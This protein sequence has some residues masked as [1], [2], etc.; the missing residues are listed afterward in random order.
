MRIT[1]RGRYALRASLALVRIQNLLPSARLTDPGEYAP[2]SINQISEEEQISSVFLEQIF[3]KLRKAGIVSSVRGPGGGFLFAKSPG[4]I[5]L[6]EILD[7]AGEEL[8]VTDCDK[9]AK[10]C[11]ISGKKC[12]SHAV[13]EDVTKILD[14]YFSTVTLSMVIERNLK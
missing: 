14:N 1:T 13:W 5:T 9:N 2:V 6:K 12:S 4:T 10:T 11:K 7:A 3:F 8:D